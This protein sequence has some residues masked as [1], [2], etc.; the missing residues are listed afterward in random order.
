[1]GE[2]AID[3]FLGGVPSRARRLTA[4]DEGSVGSHGKDRAGKGKVMVLIRQEKLAQILGGLPQSVRTI[5][6][7]VDGH[8]A[9]EGWVEPGMFSVLFAIDAIQNKLEFAGGAVE[10]GVHHG[11]FFIALANLCDPST[12]LVAID[13]FDDQ[14]KNIDGSG[15]GDEAAFRRNV[16]AHCNKRN[17]D[18]RTIKADSL[19][20]RVGE[21]GGVEGGKFRFVSID[22]GHTAMHAYNDLLLAEHL[23]GEGGV[24]FVDDILNHHW[25]GVMEGVMKYRMFSPAAL[26]P[27][28]VTA[29]KMMMCKAPHHATYFEFFAKHFPMGEK[30]SYRWTGDFLTAGI[31]P[32]LAP[33]GT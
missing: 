12:D 30:K 4:L 26:V 27:F 7:A 17:D 19:N 6:Y 10:I 31:A 20:L 13:V 16:D 22:G 33:T 24:V 29:N 21:P 9:V 32:A 23:L 25:M 2:N 8:K 18:I 11:R 5:E 15:K 3:G 1:M 14:K 28:L